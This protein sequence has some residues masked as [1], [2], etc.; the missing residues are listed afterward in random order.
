[1]ASHTEHFRESKGAS[2]RSDEAGSPIQMPSCCE[3]KALPP[4]LPP[5]LPRPADTSAS[6]CYYLRGSAQSSKGC[7]LEQ[8]LKLSFSGDVSDVTNGELLTAPK[9]QL[10]LRCNRI[11]TGGEVVRERHVPW[12][13]TAP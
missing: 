4:S 1:M 10:S 9:T 13:V 2:A 11:I 12:P 5:S 8:E 6:L 7:A 3:M